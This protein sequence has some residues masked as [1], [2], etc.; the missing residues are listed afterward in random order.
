MRT[1]SLRLAVDAGDGRL[2]PAAALRRE[3]PLL[4]LVAG[5]SV[6]AT[7]PDH[8]D[9]L[10]LAGRLL[11]GDQAAFDSFGERYFKVLYRFVLARLGG[12][13][14][15]TV[16]IVQTT[17]AKALAK[18]GSYRGRASLLSW[19]CACCLNEIR[20]EL[21]RLR[22]RPATAALEPDD[23]TAAGSDP[24]PNPE[25]RLLEAEVA[26]LVHTALDGLP[27]HYARALEWRY[28]DD[29]PVQQVAARLGVRFKAAESI[30]SR[31]RAA[32]RGNFDRLRAI[33]RESDD[34][35]E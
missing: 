17:L 26:A 18:L 3:R 32:F 5:A 14:E 31:A 24:R 33:G 35:H 27:S 8:A 21:R 30:L 28:L 6:P 13:R 19:L 34:Q 1:T 20:M 9:D 22:N 4:A 10:R 12:D 25:A 2:G 7:V 11:A 16:E 23:P 15:R 29:L